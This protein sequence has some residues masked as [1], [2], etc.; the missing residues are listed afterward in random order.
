MEFYVEKTTV[1]EIDNRHRDVWRKCRKKREISQ[2]TVTTVM[3]T[4][5][6]HLVFY[7]IGNRIGNTD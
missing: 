3:M 1:I 2:K 7:R 6:R 4:V 5:L